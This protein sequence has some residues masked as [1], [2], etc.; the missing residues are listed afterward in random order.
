VIDDPATFARTHKKVLWE[1]A[2]AQGMFDK[3]IVLR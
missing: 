3:R 2:R 1:E